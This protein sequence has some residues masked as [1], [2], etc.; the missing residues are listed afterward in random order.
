MTTWICSRTNELKHHGIKGQKWGIRRF[1]NKDGS[2]TLLGKKRY[3]DDDIIIE[4]GSKQRHISEK[5]EIRLNDKETYLYDPNNK[6]DKKVYEGAYAM[7]I[8]AGK[9]DMDKYVH[10]YETTKTLRM[11]SN[12]RSVDIF[13]KSYRNNPA[14]YIHEMNQ[15]KNY[16]KELSYLT[17]YMPPIITNKEAIKQGILKIADKYNMLITPENKQELMYKITNVL[18]ERVDMRIA[19]VALEEL[20][21]E[22]E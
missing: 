9:G 10:E 15:I 13:I 12:K 2:L 3:R 20:I 19:A 18:G 11:P 21:D 4:K 1:Q 5:R 17:I 16:Y 7:Y 22:T 14:P 6:H 8:E